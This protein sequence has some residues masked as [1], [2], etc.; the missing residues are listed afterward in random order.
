MPYMIYYILSALVVLI[1]L[2]VHE[3]S[4]GFAAYKL[5]D[6]TAKSLGRLSLNPIKHLD[7][8]GAICM[9]FFHVGWAKPVPINARYFKKPKRDFA[10]VALAG[11]LANLVM[12]FL[13][14]FLYLF[15]YALWRDIVF[16]SAFRLALAENVLLFLQLFHVINIGLAIFNLLPIPPFDG[17]R[18]LNVILP[19]RIYFSIM[20]YERQIYFFVLGWLFLGDIAARAIMAIPLASQSVALTVIAKILSLSDLLGTV[21]AFISGLMLRFWQ[22]IP[23]LRI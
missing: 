22:L 12:A 4:H 20:K 17:S 8:I 23:F 15:L 13:S 9:L 5:G 21:N 6:P 3:F 18:I 19:Q 1:A 14:A 16:V 7:P 10:L 11:P 2:T